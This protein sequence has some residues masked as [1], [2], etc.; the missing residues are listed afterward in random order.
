LVANGGGDA[1]ERV[2]KG[3][4]TALG[5]E[6]GWD[7]E[8][9]RMLLVVGDAP[10]HAETETELLAMVERAHN[11][12]FAKGKGPVTGKAQPLRPFIT[13][14]IATNAAAKQ[15]FDAIAQAGGGA[16]V[17]LDLAAMKKVD[18]KPV[19][20]PQGRTAAQQIAE[21]VLLLSFGAGYEAQLRAFVDVFFR[22]RNAGAL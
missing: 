15:S 16:S 3:I 13:S 7:K 1:P 14:A 12:P 5:K 9:N 2:E 8:K 22:Y 19:G 17:L 18:G 20:G 21:H 11:H 4:E 10:P 6:M